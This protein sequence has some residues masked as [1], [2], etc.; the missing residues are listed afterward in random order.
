MSLDPRESQTQRIFSEYDAAIKVVPA[1]EPS[2]KSDLESLYSKAVAVS[3]ASEFEEH[4]T[5]IV[6][7]A[8]DVRTTDPEFSKYL[9]D[10]LVVRK[11]FQFFD[12]KA[13]NF[14]KLWSMFPPHAKTHCETLLKD[15]PLLDGR[16]RDFMAV[17]RERNRLVHQNFAAA[18]PEYT[19]VE[20][21]S[22]FQS[23]CEAVG[24]IESALQK[25]ASSEEVSSTPHQE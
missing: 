14:N 21:F 10:S 16:I 25:S 18:S 9:K 15:N 3:A 1:T 24:L 8:F 7:N 19:V 5:Q 22:L 11:Y 13:N 6:A 2:I 12:F 4:V 20:I 23:G 17:N